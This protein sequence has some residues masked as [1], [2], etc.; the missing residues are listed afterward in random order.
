MTTKSSIARNAVVLQEHRD[1]PGPHL[2]LNENILLNQIAKD[3]AETKQIAAEVKKHHDMLAGQNT[4]LEVIKKNVE[5][6]EQTQE[7]QDKKLDKILE[8]LEE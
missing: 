7:K 5:H 6:I 1:N 4:Q 8:K 2:D 3:A